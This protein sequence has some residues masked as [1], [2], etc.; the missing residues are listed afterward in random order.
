MRACACACVHVRVHVCVRTQRLL[1][2][3][4]AKEAQL[5][6]VEARGRL[7]M[8]QTSP[9]GAAAVQAE[10]AELAGAWQALRLL[11]QSLLR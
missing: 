4:P 5:P 11:E 3:F 6:L 8:E 10:L 9:E 7:V 1:A 2:E